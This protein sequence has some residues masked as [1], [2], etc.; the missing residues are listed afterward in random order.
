MKG[1]KACP[2]CGG[3]AKYVDLGVPGEFSDWDVECTKCGIVVMCP[4]AEA[5]AVTS[6]EEAKAAWNRRNGDTVQVTRC[7]DCIYARFDTPDDDIGHC[8]TLDQQVSRMWFCA[9]GTKEG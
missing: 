5:G 1:L 4:G 8:S 6:K 7:S 9:I 3:A 2:F